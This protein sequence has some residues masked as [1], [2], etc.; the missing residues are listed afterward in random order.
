MSPIWSSREP[1][2]ARGW[3][4]LSPG[5]DAAWLG[6]DLGTG[7]VKAAVVDAQ[8]SVRSQATCAY[9]VR[10]P[11]PGWAEIDPAEWLI[12][13]DRAA[14]QAIAAATETVIEG[15]GFSGQMHGVVLVD[16]AGQALRPAILWADQ[17]SATQVRQLAHDFTGEHLARLGS[18][19]VAGFAATSLAW[20][21]DHEP[22]VL[23]RARWA[24]QP[25][26]WLRQAMGGSVLTDPSDASGTLLA[27][28]AR[29]VWDDQ[30]LAWSGVR[31]E[32]IAPIVDSA[33]AA[34]SVRLASIEVPCVVGGA[35]T[36]CALAGIGLLPGQGFIAVGTGSQAVS[37]LSRPDVDATL[38]THTFC[39]VGPPAT[40]WYRIGAVQ[41]AGLALE[42]A[43]RWFGADV[44]EAHAA[45]ADGI[46]PDDPIFIPTLSGERTPY[47][48]PTMTGSW[49]GLR[50]S[51]DRSAMLRS[52]LEGI[53][54]GIALAVAAVRDS[55]APWPQVTALVGGG[56]TDP[57]FRQLLADATGC[58][59]GVMEAPNAAV[60]GAAMLAMGRV[61]SPMGPTTID[62]IEP[63]PG[64]QAL[65][66]DR[67][68]AIVA[69]ATRR[70]PALG[71]DPSAWEG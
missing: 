9:R 19:A 20:L 35:D 21:R 5:A 31:R 69:E 10:S 56:S 41:N 11:R 18:A 43:L 48:D 57:A 62:V 24:L 13:A 17:R 46:R 53:S 12:A 16:E 52:L 54:Q 23:H 71:L 36:A 40:S 2:D 42:V 64:Q 33:Q 65:L 25:K 63:D 38:A 7:S 39:G 44:S 68:Q 37:M 45:L 51:T 28:V 6:V 3:S 4:Q 66:A 29:G 30:V 8:G 60:V 49:Q 26:D 22:D 50:L 67:R 32:Q 1:Q 47:M 70:R 59:L 34:G 27:D 14:Q 55:G 58:R 61:R 15:V